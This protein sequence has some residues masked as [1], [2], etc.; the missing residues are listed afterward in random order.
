MLHCI[1][2]TMNFGIRSLFTGVITIIV[3]PQDLSTVMQ[4]VIWYNSN[5]R[6][7]NKPIVWKHWINGNIV[8]ICDIMSDTTDDGFETLENIVAKYQIQTNWLEYASLKNAITPLWKNN[9]LYRQR[10]HCC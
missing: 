1:V 8:H 4:Q 5:I 3:N 10:R 7:Q 6:I 9:D 2:N